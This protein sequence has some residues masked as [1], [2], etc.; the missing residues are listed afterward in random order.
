M[1]IELAGVQTLKSGVRVLTINEIGDYRF[2]DTSN[3]IRGSLYDSSRDVVDV[4]LEVGGELVL[5]GKGIVSVEWLAPEVIVRILPKFGP[6]SALRLLSAA[7]EDLPLVGGT[8]LE[9]ESESADVFLAAILRSLLDAL[10]IVSANGRDWMDTSR[11]A[12]LTHVESE[13][14]LVD[15]L[16]ASFDSGSVLIVQDRHELDWNTLSNRAIRTALGLVRNLP[17]RLEPGL[18]GRLGS[19]LASWWSI[20]PDPSPRALAAILRDAL[21]RGSAIG[22]NRQYYLPALRWSLA[23]LECSG[24]SLDVGEDL[25]FSPV[26]FRMEDLFERACRNFIRRALQGTNLVLSGKEYGALKDKGLFKTVKGAMTNVRLEPDIVVLDSRGTE[27]VAAADVKYKASPTP[28]DYYQMLAYSEA[29]SLDQIGLV[30]VSVPAREGEGES[31][32]SSRVLTKAV[33][34][35][36]PDLGSEDLV[37]W[38]KA[39][40]MV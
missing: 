24:P 33:N 3:A 34:L 7:E 16:R 12:I 40:L 21:A 27:V 8:E 35:S 29:L 28:D 6:L 38:F 20:D 4:R 10:D 5:R 17:V 18:D 11:R 15:S 14:D 23:I 26:R 1:S 31:H 9:Y 22:P 37:S 32:R 19:A 13:P 36:A 30:H 25:P 39:R 2:R